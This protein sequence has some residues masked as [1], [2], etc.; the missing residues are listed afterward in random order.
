MNNSSVKRA[1]NSDVGQPPA[2]PVS[3]PGVNQPPGKPPPS[4][5]PPADCRPTDL[6]S[7][8]PPPTNLPRVAPPPPTIGTMLAAPLDPPMYGPPLPP[9]HK[10][11]KPKRPPV[12]PGSVPVLLLCVTAAALGNLALQSR[13]ASIALFLAVA[14]TVAVILFYPERRR[15]QV[16]APAAIAVGAAAVC[17]IRVSPWITGPALLAIATSLLVASQD[18]LGAL[19]TP[20]GRF[21]RDLPIVPEWFGVSRVSKTVEKSTTRSIA[22]EAA[23]AVLVVVPLGLLLASGDAIFASFLGSAANGSMIGHVLLTAGLLIPIAALALAA[24]RS[25]P[26]GDASLPET[27]AKKPSAPFEQL[28]PLAAVF[29]LLTFWCVSQIA[30]FI[31]GAERFLNTADTTAAE[32]THQ[33]FFQLVAA[34]ALVVATITVMGRRSTHSGRA[35]QVAVFLNVALGIETIGLIGTTYSRLALYMRGFGLTMLRLSVAWFLA[36][37]AVAVVVVVASVAIANWKTSRTAKLIYLTLGVW[38]VGF[39]AFNP[40]AFVVERNVEAQ[41]FVDQEATSR[42][43]PIDASYLLN[44]LGPD[45]IPAIVS[46]LDALLSNDVDANDAEWMKD[47]LCDQAPYENKYG[48]LSYNR[49]T[50]KA[51]RALAAMNC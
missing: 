17:V 33:G 47:V 15:T 40:E 3:S 28:I 23:V 7:V 27:E 25:Q 12:N 11:P 4:D 26:E 18:R 30:V 49:S 32:Y 51:N 19:I 44:D 6:P 1:Q 5:R 14:A 48:F 41:T 21:V 39:G 45:A 10:P 22:R 36:W 29:A 9:G 13:V 16:Y 8:P 46:H 34:A 43:G 50:E 35:R 42:R 24:G 38:V 37:L 31:G 20:L 2:A